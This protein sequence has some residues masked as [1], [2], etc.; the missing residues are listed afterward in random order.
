MFFSSTLSQGT[1]AAWSR[2]LH[3]GLDAGLSLPRIFR[4]QATKGPPEGRWLAADI[5]LSLEQGEA[6]EDALTTHSNRLPGLF[7]QM[8]VVGEQT[9]HMVDVFRELEEYY[10][11]QQ[12]LTRQFRSQITLPVMQFVMGVLVIAGLIWILGFIA[13]TRGG[14]PIA[15]I[16][17]GLVGASGAVKFLA[18]VVGFIAGVYLGYRL[19]T[20]SLRQLRGG[21]RILAENSQHRSLY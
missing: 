3:H 1:L 17:F 12:S 9:G 8:T 5:A 7:L 21:G 2:A 19:L 13:E 6:L 16:G 18:I 15:P 20:R 10:T 11:L 14:A 4:L